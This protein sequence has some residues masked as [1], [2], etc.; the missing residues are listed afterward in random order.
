MSSGPRPVTRPELQMTVPVAPVNSEWIGRLSLERD[1]YA[2]DVLAVQPDWSSL[3]K[4]LRLMPQ[5]TER[6]YSGNRESF[7]FTERTFPFLSVIFKRAHVHHVVDDSGA[8]VEVFFTGHFA[9]ISRIN[10]FGCFR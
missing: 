8:P 2:G 10:A 4:S 9:V 3:A 5:N 6:N 1:I 7:S